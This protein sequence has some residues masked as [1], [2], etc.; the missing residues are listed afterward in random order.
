MDRKRPPEAHCGARPCSYDGLIPEGPR[1]GRVG[2]QDGCRKEE[3]EGQR[4]T[5]K[6]VKPPCLRS[7]AICREMIPSLQ[8]PACSCAHTR[9]WSCKGEHGAAKESTV[10]RPEGRVSAARLSR[11]LRSSR[12]PCC[13]RLPTGGLPGSFQSLTHIQGPQE[14]GCI[15]H[16][17][18]TDKRPRP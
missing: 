3:G 17:L 18:F 11:Q 13:H 10:G 4:E 8:I 6:T 15:I 16:V 5:G 14:P 2:S 9:V 7:K 12:E 1:Q